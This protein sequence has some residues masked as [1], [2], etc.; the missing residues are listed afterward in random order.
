M[1]THHKPI[2]VEHDL[3]NNNSL[4]IILKVSCILEQTALSLYLD[5]T[6]T[7]RFMPM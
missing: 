6:A 3:A 4:L 5:E 7:K 1:T 2:Y